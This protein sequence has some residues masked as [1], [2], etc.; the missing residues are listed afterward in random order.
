MNTKTK[1]VGTVASAVATVA[2]VVGAGVRYFLTPRK[3]GTKAG[4]ES[5][6]H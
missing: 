5:L 6:G 3:R 1:R 2:L 4:G